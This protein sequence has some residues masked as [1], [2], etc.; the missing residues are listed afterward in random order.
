MRQHLPMIWLGIGSAMLLWPALEKRSCAQVVCS[1][2][3][4]ILAIFACGMLL[5]DDLFIV[6]FCCGIFALV[7]WIIMRRFGIFDSNFAAKK[8]LMYHLVACCLFFY[9]EYWWLRA[10]LGVALFP[11]ALCIFSASFPFH[12]WVEHF[13]SHAPMCLGAVFLLFF[14]PFA[15]FFTLQFL[16]IAA[17]VENYGFSEK[18]SGVLGV[19]GC[20]FL[21]ILFFSKEENRKFLGYVLCWQNSILWLSLS[22][23]EVYVYDLLFEFS[24]AQGALLTLLLFAFAG[25]QRRRQ[26][27]SIIC[28]KSICCLGKPRGFVIGIALV[29]LGIWPLLLVSSRFMRMSCLQVVS[30]TIS[31]LLYFCFLCCTFL[32]GDSKL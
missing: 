23:C 18:F 1:L 2:V 3:S 20:L 24:I 19:L 15:W 25:I 26:S 21:P 8:F 11:V 16:S 29:L 14:R 9:A 31:C 6:P 22:N 10:R 13:F 7:G 27:D 12:G 28:L 30:L 5:R 17:S 4:V 32:K